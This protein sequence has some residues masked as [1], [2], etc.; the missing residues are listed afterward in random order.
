MAHWIGLGVG[1]ASVC[2][3]SLAAGASQVLVEDRPAQVFR[4]GGVHLGVELEDVSSQDVSRLKLPDERGALVKRVDAESPAQK[5]GLKEGD[6]IL[7]Y[8]GES[9]LSVLQLV[10]LVRE[11]P[12]GRTVSLE[13]S[14]N[15]AIQKLTATLA[16][17]SS[18][19]FGDLKDMNLK[20]PFPPNMDRL[21]SPDHNFLFRDRLEGRPKRLGIEYQEISGQLAK[22][23]RLTD[24]HGILVSSVDE[25]GPAA[26]AGIK[27]GDV[28]LKF[29]GKTVRDAGQFREEVAK[30]EA[31]Q[32][33][34]LTLQREGK[35]V[36]VKL[37]TGGSQQPHPTRSRPI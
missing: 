4:L 22:Y 5:A 36:D 12:P 14:R 13:V 15:G 35:T 29:N 34:S 7:R 9:I 8:Q 33:V 26:K 21:V 37:K 32:E 18:W 24:D 17:G 27:A 10:R 3:A 19:N 2:A 20:V 6:V 25:D 23:F 16:Q 28:I 31:D 1:V 11:T 30:T